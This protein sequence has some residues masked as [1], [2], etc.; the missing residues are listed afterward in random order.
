MRESVHVQ[1]HA[2]NFTHLQTLS[3][4]AWAAFYSSYCKGI[5][6]VALQ[7]LCGKVYISGNKHKEAEG[8]GALS[9]IHSDLLVV[10]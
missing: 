10:S 2:S 7:N 5:F 9:L 6:P 1:Q 8:K 3:I 4:N